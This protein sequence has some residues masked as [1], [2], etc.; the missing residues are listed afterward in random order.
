MVN[1][2][3]WRGS[4]FFTVE[5]KRGPFPLLT[6]KETLLA[7]LLEERTI[8]AMEEVQKRRGI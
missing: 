3:R 1:E 6:G 5:G 2:D 8:S 7:V 4:T